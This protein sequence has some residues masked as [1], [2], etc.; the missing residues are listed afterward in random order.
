MDD[1]LPREFSNLLGQL[2][3]LAGRTDSLLGAL[4]PSTDKLPEGNRGLSGAELMKALRPLSTP[5]G[6]LESILEAYADMYAIGNRLIHGSM[7]FSGTVLSVWYV[8][9][10]RKGNSALS[11]MM[12]LEQLEGVVQS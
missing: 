7:N 3:Y 1:E 5:G 10:R 2:A 6:K 12:T 4:A 9:T 8:P 11:M